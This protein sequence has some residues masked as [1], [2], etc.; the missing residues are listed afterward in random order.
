MR[1]TFAAQKN[2][3][4]VGHTMRILRQRLETESILIGW[5]HYCREYIFI[6]LRRTH[7]ETAVA[8]WGYSLFSR[9]CV[10]D[11]IGNFKAH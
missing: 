2:K 9:N 1:V 4:A 6:V 7:N 10:S 8:S 5:I 3:N 11:D